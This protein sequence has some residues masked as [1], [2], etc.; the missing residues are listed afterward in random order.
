MKRLGGLDINMN[1]QRLFLLT[2][3]STKSN[4]I[5]KKWQWSKQPNLKILKVSLLILKSIL[6]TSKQKRL[7][8]A[9]I[10]Q[11]EAAQAK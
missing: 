7:K 9:E 2:T 11:D 1:S 8:P 5:R 10:I 4:K 6:Q 3:G